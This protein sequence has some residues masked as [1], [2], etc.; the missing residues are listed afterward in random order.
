MKGLKAMEMRTERSYSAPATNS[1]INPSGMYGLKVL[2]NKGKYVPEFPQ[3]ASLRPTVR[4][5]ARRRPGCRRPAGEDDGAAHAHGGPQLQL[6]Q[7][8]G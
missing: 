1:I 6:R 7:V 3:P 8:H 4:P 5:S 2:D